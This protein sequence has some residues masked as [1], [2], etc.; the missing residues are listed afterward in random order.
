MCGLHIGIPFD[1]TNDETNETDMCQRECA[2]VILARDCVTRDKWAKNERT[3]ECECEWNCVGEWRESEPRLI[4]RAIFVCTRACNHEIILYTFYIHIKI[5][6]VL[7]IRHCEK[8]WTGVELSIDRKKHE[9]HVRSRRR[10]KE[11]DVACRKTV[12]NAPLISKQCVNIST[13]SRNAMRVKKGTRSRALLFEIDSKSY[14]TFDSSLESLVEWQKRR[15]RKENNVKKM[16]VK[17]ESVRYADKILTYTRATTRATN[18]RH[19]RPRGNSFW[20]SQSDRGVSSRS[21]VHSSIYVSVIGN[22]FL[23][24]ENERKKDRADERLASSRCIRIRKDCIPAAIRAPR[25]TRIS[26][27][28]TCLKRDQRSGRHM[29]T[30]ILRARKRLPSEFG[31]SRKNFFIF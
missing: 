20:F 7:Q 8:G 27:P 23:S 9:R 19:A 4:F 5:D 18:T 13:L 15:V 12:S 14:L 1:Y 24:L 11:H 26:I 2:G 25:D 17:S 22:H 16:N 29:C 21:N 31:E 10:T 28:A 6:N 30:E 3:R